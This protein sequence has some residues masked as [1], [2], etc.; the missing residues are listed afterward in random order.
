M[1]DASTVRDL[2]DENRK[3]KLQLEQE[4]KTPEVIE[5]VDNRQANEVKFGGF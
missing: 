4:R 1:I 5:I 2:Q 3:L